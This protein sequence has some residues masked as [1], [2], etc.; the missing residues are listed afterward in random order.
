M[1]APSLTLRAVLAFA[2]FFS[3]ALPGARAA[4]ILFDASHAETA[5]NADWVIDEDNSVPQRIPTPPQANITASTPETYWTGAISAWGIAMVKRGHQ[6][7]TLP[8]GTAITFG[9]SSNVQDLSHYNVFA[10]I[11]PNRVFSAAEKTA[12]M[13]YV[14]AGGRLFLCADHINS[15]RDN[16]GWDSPRIWNDLFA[17]NSVQTAPFGLVFNAD[18]ISPANETADSALDNPL[19]HGPAGTVTRFLY[20]NGASIT[21]NPAANPS[22]RAAIWTTSTHT[23]SNVMVAFGTFGAGKFVAVGDSSPIDDGTGAPNNTLFDGW[24]DRSGDD[25]RLVVNATLWLIAD[26]IQ[27]APVND[28]F[29]NAIVLSGNSVNATGSNVLATKEV[30]EPN[31]GGNPGGKSVWW[32]WTP[33]ASG[34]AVISTNGSSFSSLLGVYTGNSVDSLTPV[35]SSGSQTNLAF[36]AVAGVTYRIA[37]DGTDGASGNIQLSIALTVA[38]TA[39]PATIASW[40]FDTTPYPNPLSSSA[41]SGSISFSAWGGTVTNFGGVTGQALALQGTAGNG[42]YIE[43]AFSMTGYSGLNLAFATRGTSTGYNSGTWS[44]SVNGGPFTTLPGV[45][46]ATTSTTFLNKTVDFTGITALNNATQVRLRYTLSGATGSSPNNRIDDLQIN[47]TTIAAI[48]AVAT[49]PDGYE[50]GSLPASVTFTSS[51]AAGS[52]G[53]PVQFQLGGTATP[54]GTAGADYSLSGNTNATSITIPAGATSATLMLVPL[55]DNDPTEFDETVNVTVQTSAA[56]FVGTPAAA[57]VTIHDDTP[58]NSTWVSQFPGFTGANAAPDLDLD[59]DGLTNFGEF[60]FNGDPF[61]SDPSI[62]PVQGTID[63]PDPNDNNVI[64]RYPT[65]IFRRR[66]DA[67]N[68]IYTP[69]SSRDLWNWDQAVQFVSSVAGPGPSMETVT[70]RGTYPASGN[71][72]VVPGFLRVRVSSGDQ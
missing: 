34:D 18:N 5:G 23:N 10:V 11:E 17:T 4:S 27:Q 66:N 45:N 36:S 60:A 3:F 15:D 30:G 50:R 2:L 13:Q 58:Y 54:P 39:G 55:A 26:Q 1:P 21:I 24:D 16:D 7:E 38:T 69:Q 33:A 71:G 64:K 32:N 19:T 8:V 56:Y 72:A 41:G 35:V 20:A 12:I 25:A 63:L 9:N 22:V 49:N 46:T 65:I 43:L 68:L 14:Q 52:G 44:W 28:N 31:H 67:P 51:L 47:A 40:N 29:A 53:L 37:V 57:T 61:R 62:L 59:G 70:Y 48:T 6:V 42:T